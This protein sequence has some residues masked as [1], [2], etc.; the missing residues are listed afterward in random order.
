MV[1]QPWACQFIGDNRKTMPQTEAVQNAQDFDLLVAH[2]AIYKPHVAAMKEANP[3]LKLLVYVNSTFTYRTNL[4]ASA[5]AKD[6]NGNRITAQGW[7]S[8]YLLDPSNSAARTFKQQEAKDLLAK[9][10]YGDLYLDVA[11]FGPLSPT[12]VSGLPI[13]TA[14][15]KVWEK[16]DWAKALNAHITGIRSAVGPSL[17]IITNSLSSAPNY[18]A[19]SPTSIFLIPAINGAVCEGWLRYAGDPVSKYPNEANWNSAVDMVADI[20]KR[21][22]DAFLITKMTTTSVQSELEAWYDYALASYMSGQSGRSY[23]SVSLKS[24][25]NTQKRAPWRLDLG[26]PSGGRA[27]VRGIYQRDF[28]NGRVLV[29]PTSKTIYVDP[30]ASSHSAISGQPISSGQQVSMAA[31]SSLILQGQ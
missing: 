6:K 30:V 29:N 7:S 21:G 27:L 8:T 9:S 1:A 20:E 26:Q 25:D 15:G 28:T 14:T 19:S 16:T 3:D 23:L 13:N 12:Y 31:N 2:E 24:G 4:S 17:Y 5:Y 18:W 22:F 11:G 10:G